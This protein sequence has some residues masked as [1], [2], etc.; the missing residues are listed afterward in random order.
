MAVR[1][2]KKV[3]Y[4]RQSPGLQQSISTDTPTEK[5]QMHTLRRGS[6]ARVLR[7]S[8]KLRVCLVSPDGGRRCLR[9][10]LLD[11]VADPYFWFSTPQIEP[12]PTEKTPVLGFLSAFR[13][14]PPVS[15]SSQKGLTNTQVIYSTSLGGIAHQGGCMSRGHCGTLYVPPG[16]LAPSL[17]HSLTHSL[18]AE[19]LFLKRYHG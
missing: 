12:C 15:D 18:L 2:R 13:F 10:Q 7:T 9:G 19:Q 17:T 4:P 6:V 5:V 8:H 14:S 16:L 1:A 11:G 3:Q